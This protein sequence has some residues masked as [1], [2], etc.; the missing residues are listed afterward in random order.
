MVIV[1]LYSTDTVSKAGT[2]MICRFS[3]WSSENLSSIL[4][5]PQMPHLPPLEPEFQAAVRTTAGLNSIVDKGF[6]DPLFKGLSTQPRNSS[7]PLRR[8][9]QATPIEAG[10]LI[11]IPEIGHERGRRTRPYNYSSMM[12]KF[13]FT[14]RSRPNCNV[15]RKA[16]VSLG[17]NLDLWCK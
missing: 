7:S 13:V 14:V 8:W 11:E 9:S 4:M 1:N 3:Y 12:Q 5:P 2:L 10:G 17:H 15:L 6:G 16:L